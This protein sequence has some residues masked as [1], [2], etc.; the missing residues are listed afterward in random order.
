MGLVEQT[1]ALGEWLIRQ[2]TQDGGHADDAVL[3]YDED[4]QPCEDHVLLHASKDD[5]VFA[6]MWDWVGHEEE[7][8]E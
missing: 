2:T 6:E 8:D 5:H 3:S 4:S 7:E 1:V